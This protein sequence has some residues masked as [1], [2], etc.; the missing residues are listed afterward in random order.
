MIENVY[1][2]RPVEGLKLPSSDQ[3]VKT[4]TEQL[5][6]HFGRNIEVPDVPDLVFQSLEARARRGIRGNEVFYLPGL[7][8]EEDDEFWKG[9]G[10]VKPGYSF[11]S[12]IRTGYYPVEV[13]YLLEGWYIGDGRGKPNYNR[14]IQVYEDDYMAPLMKA[15]RVA[16]EINRCTLNEKFFWEFP[17]RETKRDRYIAYKSRFGAS[18]LEIRETILPIFA[19]MSGAL[20]EV[21]NRRYIEFNIRGN[22]AHP[23]WGRTNT[24]EWFDDLDLIGV[25]CCGNLADVDWHLGAPGHGRIGFSPVERF[26]SQS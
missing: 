4:E 26:P 22:M 13:A 21:R 14:G 23:E 25:L 19:I 17:R 10:K 7:H 8:L 11:W 6:K 3:L 5:K 18:P 12:A 2:I 16:G 9:E 24:M 20:G 1:V 15:L